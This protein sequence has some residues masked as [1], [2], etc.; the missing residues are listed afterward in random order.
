[1]TTSS[2]PTEY[3]LYSVA[4]HSVVAKTMPSHFFTTEGISSCPVCA[5]KLEAT[6]MCSWCRRIDDAKGHVAVKAV[7]DV[8]VNQVVASL[9]NLLDQKEQKAK[10]SHL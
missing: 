8:M 5:S 9:K 6:R 1:M 3:V 7:K 10:A 2:Q 4:H